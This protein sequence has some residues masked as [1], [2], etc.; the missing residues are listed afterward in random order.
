MEDLLSRSAGLPPPMSLTQ[1]GSGPLGDLVFERLTGHEDSVVSGGA[2]GEAPM[3][4]VD[5]Y[6][7]VAG[8]TRSP[9]RQPR[10]HGQKM[11]PLSPD[12]EKEDEDDDGDEEEDEEDEEKDEDA[13]NEGDNPLRVLSEADMAVTPGSSEVRQAGDATLDSAEAKV[14]YASEPCKIEEEGSGEVDI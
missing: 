12:S 6:D 14:V 1:E 13:F 9:Q 2:S 4:D 3:E 11:R 8:L 7:P 10:K 5:S